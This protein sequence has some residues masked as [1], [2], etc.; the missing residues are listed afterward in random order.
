MMRASNFIFLLILLL[1]PAAAHADIFGQFSYNPGGCGANN[2]FDIECSKDYSKGLFSAISCKVLT[3]FSNGVIPMYCNIVTSPEY[4]SAIHAT[5]TLFV[6]FW[7][8]SFVIGAVPTTTGTAFVNLI[9]MVFIYFFSTNVGVFFDFFYVTILSI[10]SEIVGIVLRGAGNGEQ[11]F[12]VYVD[13]FF[14]EIF[15]QVFRPSLADG[16]T[17]QKVDIRLFAL[18]I[19]VGKLVPGGGIIT[20]LFYSVISGWLM[21]YLNIMVRYLLAIMALIFLLMLTPIF[22]PAKLFKSLQYVT[23]EWQK[24]IVSFII[25]IVVVVLF[26][27]MIEPFFVDFLDLVKLGFNEIVLEKGSDSSLVSQGRTI[28]GEL[29]EAVY[30]STG[31][32]VASAKEY[33]TKLNYTGDPKEFVPWFVWKLLTATVVIYLTYKFMK[34]VPRFATLIAGNPKF[35]NLM[36]S[37]SDSDFGTGSKSPGLGSEKALEKLRKSGEQLVRP[38]D[39]SRNNSNN[40]NAKPQVSN[41]SGSASPVGRGRAGGGNAIDKAAVDSLDS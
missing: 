4:L 9:K 17:A 26:L 27:I 5:M 13:R 28:G 24:M 15:N 36:Q 25:Q 31:V 39:A 20:A 38:S 41:R 21:A 30:K 16:S 3:A 33:V 10:P 40:A 1:V 2:G 29:V 34:N 14:F 18:G 11:D 7:G 12:F 19:A 6:I 32:T 35:A 37:V 8:I 22:L 23:D